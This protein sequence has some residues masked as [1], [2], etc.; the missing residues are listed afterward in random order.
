MPPATAITPA[1][2]AAVRGVSIDRSRPRR[3]RAHAAHAYTVARYSEVSAST[4]PGVRGPR[5]AAPRAVIVSSVLFMAGTACIC[6]CLYLLT[7]GGWPGYCLPIRYPLT[8]CPHKELT[9]A[10]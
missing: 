9:C 5:P 2:Q 10:H 4:R 6:N 7:L 1:N 3:R 8:F